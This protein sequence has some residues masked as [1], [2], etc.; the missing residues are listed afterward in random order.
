VKITSVKLRDA[1]FSGVFPDCVV[2]Y[3]TEPVVIYEGCCKLI[4]TTTEVRKRINAIT[5][6]IS[7]LKAGHLIMLI[8]MH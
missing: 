8:I 1:F 4:F 3:V 5:L 7:K 6:S 2:S